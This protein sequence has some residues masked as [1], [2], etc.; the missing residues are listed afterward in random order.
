MC[1][2]WLLVLGLLGT[3]VVLSLALVLVMAEEFHQLPLSLQ[4]MSGVLVQNRNRRT[5]FICLVVALMCVASSLGL[6]LFSDDLLMSSNAVTRQVRSIGQHQ[7]PNSFVLSVY[8]EKFN[9]TGGDKLPLLKNEYKYL[10]K[11][12][13][14][15]KDFNIK[16]K[17]SKFEGQNVLNIDLSASTKKTQENV[18]LEIKRLQSK[19]LILPEKNIGDL[20]KGD[21]L[22][23]FTRSNGDDTSR[24]KEQIISDS[25]LLSNNRT[26]ER[27][28]L[29]NGLCIHP[30]YLVFTWVMCL[31]ALATTLKLYFLIKTLLAFFM[32]TFYALLVIMG[33]PSTFIN[34]PESK[35]KIPLTYQMLLLLI[36]FLTLVAYHARLVEVTSRLDFL[37]KREAQREL[38]EMRET[39]RNN[40]QLLRNILPDHVANHFLTQDRQAEHP[41]VQFTLGRV[42]LPK[43]FSEDEVL[44]QQ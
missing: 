3:T 23:R 18:N 41:W 22:N 10:R 29:F 34:Y 13:K 37:W 20:E 39:R 1:R 12:A 6:F 11:K 4:K 35:L 28:N 16:L 8:Q 2:S 7:L 32:V 5:A 43:D 30:E 25:D 42:P 38:S 21:F 33:Y 44:R 17:K 40:R 36:V 31:V 27:S 14:L 26:S 24:L 9:R 19:D 15:L